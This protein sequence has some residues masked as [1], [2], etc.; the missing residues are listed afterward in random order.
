TYPDDFENP[1][2]VRISL[3]M[4][5]FLNTPLLYS[6]TRKLERS[7]RRDLERTTGAKGYWDDPTYESNLIILRRPQRRVSYND[8]DEGPMHHDFQWWT[9]GHFRNQYYPSLGDVDD[10]HSHKLIWIDH[11][12]KGPKDKPIR[13]KPTNLVVQ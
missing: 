8:E 10:P 5:N 3:A 12:L 1:E 7:V 13:T 6:E 9:S 2:Y 4:L 11:F